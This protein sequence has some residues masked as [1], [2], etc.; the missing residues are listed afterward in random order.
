MRISI[1][2]TGLGS[3]RTGTAVY[4]SEILS[5][6]NQMDFGHEILIFTSRKAMWHFD[7]L[8][9]DSR[10]TF[11]IAPDNRVLRALWQHSVMS[12]HISRSRINVHWGTAF[13]L[14]A[15]CNCPAVVTIHDMT[16]QLFPDTHEWFKR[17]YFPAMIGRAVRQ[18]RIVIAVSNSTREDVEKLIP[19][20]SGKIIV[21]LEAARNLVTSTKLSEV[22][23]HSYVLVVGTLEPRKNLERLLT[24]W[25]GLSQIERSG[26]KLVIAGA[27][28]WLLGDHFARSSEKDGIDFIGFVSDSELAD[29]FHGALAFAYPSLYEG[30]GLPVLEAMSKGVPVLTSNVSSMREIAE[31]AALLIEP[32]N[33]DSI[34]QG[35]A[36]IIND[37]SL[38]A[39]LSH[40]GRLRAAS[41]SWGRTASQ[42]LSALE[43]AISA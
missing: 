33:V 9:L 4:V 10:F 20:S 42:T 40:Q 34:R 7:A 14:P 17:F 6:W 41:F 29:L 43:D 15:F 11:I 27:Q 32:T 13:I 26:V 2:A 35:L 24:A 39:E 5:A 16:Y 37:S 1:D 21:T 31:G 36:R 3:P 30:F 18:A 8:G 28:G 12:W 38:R 22:N 19:N 23:L 25:C